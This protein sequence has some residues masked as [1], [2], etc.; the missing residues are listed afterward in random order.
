MQNLNE[1]IDSGKNNSI[2]LLSKLFGI[3]LAK[4]DNNKIGEALCLLNYIRKQLSKS[5]NSL[6]A[7]FKSKTD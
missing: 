1:H 5:K 4:R 3:A 6:S 7:E 2:Q